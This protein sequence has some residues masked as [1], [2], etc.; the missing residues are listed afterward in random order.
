M[1]HDISKLACYLHVLSHISS[2]AELLACADHERLRG[3][4]CLVLIHW[5]RIIP[6][7]IDGFTSVSE[8]Y[9]NWIKG[10]FQG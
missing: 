8:V 2:D 7:I 1:K 6:K 4:I 9:W 3:Y 10:S 5:A